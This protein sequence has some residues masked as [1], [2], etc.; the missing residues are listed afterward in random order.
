MGEDPQHPS[1]GLECPHCPPCPGCP[2]LAV[3]Y[4][5]QLDEKAAV[6]R[7]A[8]AGLVPETAIRSPVA[9]PHLHGY[10]NQSRLAFTRGRTGR[11]ET[12]LYAAGSH[13]VVPIPRCLIQPEGMNA[14]A[15]TTGRLARELRLLVYDERTGRGHLRYLVL[16]ADH[17]RRHFLVGLVAAE[18]AADP[19]LRALA[20]GL[21]QRHPEIAGV[22]LLV[23][24]TRGN[25]ILAGEE[26]W[27]E[28]QTRLPDRIGTADLLVSMRSFLQANHEI[29]GL[30][31]ARI[32]NV[33]GDHGVEAGTTIL[34]LY[35]GVGA[36]AFHLAQSGRR[37]LGVEA[38][39]SAVADAEAARTR[40]GI[41][42]GRLRFITARAEHFF[43]RREMLAPE[44]NAEPV[45][46]AVVNPPRA[47]CSPQVVAALVAL[48][49]RLLVYASCNPSTLARDLALLRQ[50]YIPTEATPFDML[51][52][53]PHLEALVFLERRPTVASASHPG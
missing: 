15:R 48:A 20:R 17:T 30:I 47:G 11:I 50:H 5:D 46:V 28:G 44:L 27:T 35:S 18:N 3:A 34:D 53:T 43:D 26:A 16:R 9:S 23:N 6:L 7:R 25:V 41:P 36:V 14:I 12:G 19:R 42:R 49:P 31:C 22:S 51:P 37:V 29:A 2:L 1:G 32:V 39:P 33:I 24:T 8:L 40:A 13:H 4:R 45:G 10:R 52:L 21:R 38:S